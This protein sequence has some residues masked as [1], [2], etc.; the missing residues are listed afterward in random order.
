MLACLRFIAAVENDPSLIEKVTKGW[1]NLIEFSEK[2]TASDETKFEILEKFTQELLKKFPEASTLDG[3]R[4][5]FGK[6]EW[7]IVRCS[8]TSPKIA[9]RIEAKNQKS[10]D[11]KKELLVGMLKKSLS[12]LFR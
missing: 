12:S 1:P 5:D 2:L 6:G 8:N 4:I 11:V 9:V 7:A 10:L 3:I